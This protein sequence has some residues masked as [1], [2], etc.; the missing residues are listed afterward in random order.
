MNP[1]PQRAEFVESFD[2]QL[3]ERPDGPELTVLTAIRT[4]LRPRCDGRRG[5]RDWREI[6][7]KTGLR[8]DGIEHFDL[9]MRSLATVSLRP[10]DLRC[11]CA[12]GMA[13]DEALLLQT[14]ALLQITRSQAAVRLLGEWLPQPAVSGVVKLLRW[15]AI[16]LLEAGLEIR[17]RDR[18]VTYMH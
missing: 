18:D 14:I 17:V 2:E 10:L 15:L 4:W 11:R 3:L 8:P 5:Q 1:H 7:H 13:G 16:D 6:L 12:T 9:V